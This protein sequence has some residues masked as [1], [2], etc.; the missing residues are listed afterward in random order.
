M[1][2]R[3]ERVIGTVTDAAVSSTVGDATTIPLGTSAG[4]MLHCVSTS[5]SGAITVEFHV[6]F[7]AGSAEFRLADSSNA[8]ITRSIQ[9][10]RCYALP[11]E[12]FAAMQFKVVAQTGGQSAVL[13]VAF[14]G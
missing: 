5:T 1:S 2:M 9:P 13:A 6:R 7:A 11:D 8:I 4:A 3:I 14:K 12:L 10:N